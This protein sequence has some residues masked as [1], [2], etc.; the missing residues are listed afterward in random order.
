VN[1]GMA[2][3]APGSRLLIHTTTVPARRPAASLRRGDCAGHVDRPAKA[4]AYPSRS[5]TSLARMGRADQYV[6]ARQR[7]RKF[8][9]QDDALMAP[10][11]GGLLELSDWLDEER[12]RVF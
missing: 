11:S 4:R 6:C 7:H 8:D 9:H 10:M 12:E 1:K 5:S 2:P 3:V